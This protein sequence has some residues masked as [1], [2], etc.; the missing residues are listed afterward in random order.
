MAQAMLVETVGAG[1]RVA[2]LR[3]NALSAIAETMYRQTVK[4]SKRGGGP[5]YASADDAFAIVGAT[6]ELISRQLRTGH[7]KR[8]T[9]LQPLIERL[10]L[11]LLSLPPA[12]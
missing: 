7:P 9:D 8:I 6:Y 12:P 4:A 5:A 11:G 1:P 2:E 3:G 10:I